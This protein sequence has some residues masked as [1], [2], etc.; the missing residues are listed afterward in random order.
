MPLR[1]PRVC[2]VAE[3]QPAVQLAPGH[4]CQDTAQVSAQDLRR[5]RLREHGQHDRLSRLRGR[6][7]PNS[8]MHHPNQLCQ[9]M[10]RRI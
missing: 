9:G 2:A 8:Y 4:R 1:K 10:G 6:L 3:L 5:G 7:C